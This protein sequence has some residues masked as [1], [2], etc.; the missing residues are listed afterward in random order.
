MHLNGK[1]MVKYYLIGKTY[2]EKA[3]GQKINIYGKIL[4]PGGCLPMPRGYIHAN[5]HNIETS[6]VLK[7]LGQSKSNFTWSI[8][9]KQ[10]IRF[11]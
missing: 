2:C 4:P 1:K 6:S 9:G 10:Q 7:P 3:N 8:L 5:F 11:I